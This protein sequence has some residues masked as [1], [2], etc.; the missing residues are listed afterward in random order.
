MAKR[1]MVR[2]IAFRRQSVGQKYEANLADQTV[3]QRQ[4]TVQGK[5]DTLLV[6]CQMSCFVTPVCG[7]NRRG[8]PRLNC[9]PETE[10][11]PG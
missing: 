7:A 6:D 5:S 11:C 4:E 3:R 10:N 8:K 2:Q 9:T 1:K